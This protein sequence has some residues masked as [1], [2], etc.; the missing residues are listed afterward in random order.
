MPKKRAKRDTYPY[1]LKDGRE[2]YISALLK[3]L[4]EE[5]RNTKTKE[6]DSLKW[7]RNIR[8]V[9][10]QLAKASKRG[11]KATSE[12]IRAKSRGTMIR[13]D[14]ARMKTLKPRVR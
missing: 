9:R 13:P 10:E 4:G 8:A 6:R 11:F 5:R 7:S 3:I 12:A 2:V 14:C 1:V